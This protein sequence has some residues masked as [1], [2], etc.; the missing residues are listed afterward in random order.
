MEKFVLL[1]QP[2]VKSE[3]VFQP[4]L[5]AC[6]LQRQGIQFSSGVPVTTGLCEFDLLYFLCYFHLVP[7]CLSETVCL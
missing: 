7:V 4:A 2:L 3:C 6:A 5:D 1:L